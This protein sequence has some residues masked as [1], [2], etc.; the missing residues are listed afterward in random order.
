MWI[1]L[2]ILTL[3]SFIAYIFPEIINIFTIFGGTCCTL[4]SITI[5][6]ACYY[7]L[8]GRHKISLLLFGIVLT[9]VGLTASVISILD[10]L[11]F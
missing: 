5:P 9:M 1:S 6:Y 11:K 4:I 7:K 10:G 2:F 3:S 8:N